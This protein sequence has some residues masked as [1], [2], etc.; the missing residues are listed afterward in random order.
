MANVPMGNNLSLAICM[1]EGV[2]YIKTLQNGTPT[3]MAY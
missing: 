1:S 3:L 2:F